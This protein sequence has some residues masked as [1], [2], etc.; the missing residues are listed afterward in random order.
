MYTLSNFFSVSYFPEISR[1][2]RVLYRGVSQRPENA[3]V[4]FLDTRVPV[5]YVAT[6]RFWFGDLYHFCLRRTQ[7][8]IND[9][10]VSGVVLLNEV[11]LRVFLVL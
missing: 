11:C 6:S 3:C 7:T 1:L 10:L 9:R 4:L 8:G 5:R 2:W